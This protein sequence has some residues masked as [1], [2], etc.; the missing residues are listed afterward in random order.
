MMQRKDKEIFEELSEGDLASIAKHAY[1]YGRNKSLGKKI[2][3]ILA[4]ANDCSFAELVEN[5][6]R[7]YGRGNG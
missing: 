5:W 3:N 6:D 1:F 7:L 2:M 4:K